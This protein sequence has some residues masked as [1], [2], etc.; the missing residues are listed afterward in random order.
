MSTKKRVLFWIF[1]AIILFILCAGVAW[2]MSNGIVSIKTGE[3]IPTDKFVG[4]QSFT[5]DGTIQGDLFCGSQYAVSRGVI[6]GDFIGGAN[7]INLS[8][9]VAGDVRAAAGTLTIAG[10]VGKNVNGFGGT[11]HVTDKAVVGGNIY[12]FGGYIT[13]DGKVKGVTRIY[14]GDVTLNGEFFGD[15]TVD[16]ASESNP[17]NRESEARLTVLPGTVIHG[18]LTYRGAAAAIQK[19][20]QINDYQ[21]IKPPVNYAKQW[22]HNRGEFIWKLIRLLFTTGIY[23]LIG[24]AFYKLFPKLFEK[25]GEIIRQKPL[26]AIGIGLATLVSTVFSCV[27]VLILLLL[28]L[29]IISPVIGLIFGTVAFLFYVLIFYFSTLPVSL[30]LGNALFQDKLS[31]P[32]RLGIGLVV[33]TFAK[34]TFDLL[35]QFYIL[36]SLFSVLSFILGFGVLV[37]GV[38]AL[39]YGVRDFYQTTKKGENVPEM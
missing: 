25:Q 28:A 11:I 36:G 8:G 1:P 32:Y 16:T 31:L 21:W 29:A 2:G 20:A 34:F 30:W 27:V 38:G 5:N 4:A 22:A 14:G 12:L 10:A 15:V 37:V 9:T 13:V 19:G 26:G 24:L 7:D 33:I 35:S 17:G 6:E 23:F 39:V 18:K 3:V